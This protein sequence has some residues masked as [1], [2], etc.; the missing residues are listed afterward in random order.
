MLAHDISTRLFIELGNENRQN[1]CQ[2]QVA[3]ACLRRMADGVDA[4]PNLRAMALFSRFPSRCRPAPVMAAFAHSRR[5]D[6][7]V[8][9]GQCPMADCGAVSMGP[10]DARSGMRNGMI[11]INA[12][13][14]L[15][16]KKF[17]Q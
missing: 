7:R 11:Q 6:R 5:S 9:A 15:P 12:A 16:P 2:A 14:R 10:T 3:F 13:A 4:R 17:A 8:R 1:R